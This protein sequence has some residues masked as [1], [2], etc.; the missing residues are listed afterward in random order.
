MAKAKVKQ[1]KDSKGRV[2]LKG[3]SQRSTDGM[4]IYTYVDPYGKRRYAYS[5]DLFRLREKEEQLIRDQ[6]DGLDYYVG[7]TATINMAFDRYMNTKYNLRE[8]T[9]SNYMYMFNKFVR[10]EF[11]DK[12]LSEVKYTD[13]KM[14]Y[15]H[16]LNDKNIAI[17]TLDTIQTILHPIFT[18]A[19]RDDII[20]KNPTDGVMAEIK[21]NSG[22]NK[23]IRHALTLE[24]QKAFIDEV[25]YSPEYSHWYPLFVTLLGTGMRIGECIGIRW[26]DVDF[27]NRSISVNHAVTYYTRKGTACFGVSLPKTEAGVRNI[28]LIDPVYEA[29]QNEYDRQKRDGFCT[30]ELDGMTGFIF[31]NKLGSLHNPHCINSALR[32]VTESHNAREIVE[33]KREHREPVIIPKFSAHHLRHTFCS[34]LCEAELNVKIIQQIMGHKNVETTLDIYT[35]VSFERQQNAL[36]ELSKRI[37]FI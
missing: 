18:M 5:S 16:L 15:Y 17:N 21:K 4:Y 24:Q 19:V 14:F 22:K 13:V 34:R 29:L 9:R 31:S 25:K 33:V 3:E 37:N 11:G 8:T 1:R 6:M 32:R 36:D 7:G 10:D 26:K 35:E 2:L 23:G 20:R 28:P 27:K 30:V 12:L